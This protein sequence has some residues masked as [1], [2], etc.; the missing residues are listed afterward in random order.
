VFALTFN[1]GHKYRSEVHSMS[2][3]CITNKSSV[4][5]PYSIFTLLLGE[6]TVALFFRWTQ[7]QLETGYFSSLPFDSFT[8]QFYLL[9]VRSHQ[10]EIINIKRFIQGH[11]SR[12]W[13][14]SNPRH[15][16]GIA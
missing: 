5:L 8:P 3:I 13:W 10:A 16:I 12:R 15:A 1:E 2:H 14:E 4:F 11:S 7:L 9:L 6:A